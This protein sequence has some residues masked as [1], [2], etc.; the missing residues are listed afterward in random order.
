MPNRLARRHPTA[1]SQRASEKEGQKNTKRHKKQ[2]T[3]LVIFWC[4]FV[5]F[6][7]VPCTGIA[8]GT[9]VKPSGKPTG[10]PPYPVAFG[11][12]MRLPLRAQ[13]ASKAFA[14]EFGD[15]L[16]DPRRRLCRPPGLAAPRHPSSPTIRI[17]PCSRS[18]YCST[19]GPRPVA[20]LRIDHDHVGRA[21][22]R[23]PTSRPSHSADWPVSL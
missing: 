17:A 5:F 8:T 22:R 20:L 12:A 6:V 18:S 7:A 2:V 4:L 23:K 1:A 15:E 11:V 16:S 21:G 10:V 3:E 9:P 19:G 13:Q 14:A